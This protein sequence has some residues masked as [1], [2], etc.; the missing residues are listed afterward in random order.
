L[1]QPVLRADSLQVHDAAA[2]SDEGACVK[3]KLPIDWSNGGG[4]WKVVDAEI[5]EIAPHAASVATF[6]V[7]RYPREERW[8]ADW[9]V[10][11]VETGFRVGHGR[12][13]QEA[14]DM[15]TEKLKTKSP[16]QVSAAMAKA[17]RA[18]P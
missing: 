7:H 14:I 5:I 6:A 15:A 18:H 9:A 16:E 8:F 2:L 3:I 12:T 4:K 10:S 1:P 17:H 13:R 11:N